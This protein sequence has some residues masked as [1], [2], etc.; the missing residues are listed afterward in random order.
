MLDGFNSPGK[1]N[2]LVSYCCTKMP[3]V[4]TLY[5][6]QYNTINTHSVTKTYSKG[7]EKVSQFEGVQIGW[8]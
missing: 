5:R 1:E 2:D 4:Q 3:A 8:L 6:I 7:F